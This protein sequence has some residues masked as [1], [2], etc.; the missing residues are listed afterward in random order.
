MNMQSKNLGLSSAILGSACCVGPA[1]LAFPSVFGFAGGFF[2]RYHW[3]FIGVGAAGVAAA[4]WQFMQER[5]QLRA[6][7]AQMRNHG[8]TQAILV[9]ST[10]LIVAVF[11]FGAYPLLACRASVPAAGADSPTR[12]C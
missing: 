7:A 10:V 9:F 2:S 6:G 4:W 12:W 11:A 5:R 1:L 8:V 3:A